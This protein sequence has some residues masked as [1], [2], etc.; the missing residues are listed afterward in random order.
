MIREIDIVGAVNC[1]R[2]YTRSI[3]DLR[4]VTDLISVPVYVSCFI[5]SLNSL[6]FC[7]DL[8][9]VECVS[10]SFVLRLLAQSL[11]KIFRL[12]N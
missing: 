6:E 7:C 5:Q 1:L 3:S 2:H 9:D 8:S 4:L 12:T 11:R 10:S